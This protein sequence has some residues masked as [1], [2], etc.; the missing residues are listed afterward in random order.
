MLGKA[1]ATNISAVFFSISA[2]S[3]V[4]K[5]IGEGE[6]LVGGSGGGEVVCEWR[7][8]AMAKSGASSCDL[9]AVVVALGTFDTR[10]S[11]RR[12][13]PTFLPPPT[14]VRV[15]FAVAAHVAPA[16]IFIDEVD[17]LLSAR[18][19]DGGWAVAIGV[20]SGMLYVCAVQQLGEQ[21][22]E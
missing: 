22:L 20:C 9:A 4:S 5:W 8:R 11:T 14:Q 19:A 7:Q 17:S 12:S 18:K 13:I 6:K 16:V 2:S 1:I 3:L 10:R 21:H 15:L